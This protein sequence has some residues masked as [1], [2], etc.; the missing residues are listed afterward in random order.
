MF[1]FCLNTVLYLF[2][3]KSSYN[4]GIYEVYIEK[5]STEMFQ[6]D[7]QE[8]RKRQDDRLEILFKGYHKRLN[9]NGKLDFG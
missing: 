9:T 2:G 4:D 1:D 6:I 8:K 7:S 5:I 3:C